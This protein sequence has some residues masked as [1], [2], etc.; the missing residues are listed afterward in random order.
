MPDPRR[1][2]ITFLIGLA[3]MIAVLTVA[4][5]LITSTEAFVGLRDW[6]NSISADAAASRTNGATD[7]ARLVTKAGD[8]LAIVALIAGVTVVLAVLRKWR[9]M[10]FLPLAMLAEITTFLAVNHLV[11]RE[12]PPVERIGSLPSTNSFPSGHVAATLV[13]WVG[14]SLLLAGYGFVKWARIVAAFGT[15][16]A[17]AMAWARVYAGMHYTTDVIFGFVMGLAALALAVISTGWSGRRFAGR[18]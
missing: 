13:C 2:A 4:G 3:T 1:L 11:G 7:L 8:T 5:V 16:M 10:V 15:L 6:D 17:F 18:W 12:R 9:A 14:I